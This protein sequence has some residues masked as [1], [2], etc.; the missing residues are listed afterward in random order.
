MTWR[1]PVPPRFLALG[2]FVFAG[3]LKAGPL[4]SRLPVDLTLLTGAIL[5][6]TVLLRWLRGARV[7]SAAGLGLVLGWF[8]TFLPGAA[9]TA[10]T[11]YGTRKLATLA[12]FS[13]LAA[14]APFF[15]VRDRA[16]QAHALEGLACLC[17]VITLDALSGMGQGGLQRLAASGGGTIALGRAAGFLALA[18]AARFAAG[19]R[20]APL[21]LAL[22]AAGTVAALFSG[23]RGPMGGLA[24][25]LVLLLAAAGRG[26]LR[27]LAA[28]GASA[29]AL[30]LSLAL[31]PAGSLRRV[32]D[33]LRGEFGASEAY[34]AL[35]AS[36]AW[37]RIPGAPL[38]LGLGGFATQVDL[39]AGVARQYPHNLLLET[40]LEAGWACGLATVALLG[41][42]LGR[43]WRSGEALLFAGVG[44]WTL[45]ALVSGD[46]NDNRP[47]FALL[48]T[49]L[50]RPGKDLP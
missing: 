31:G 12:T 49:A 5:A 43:A 40:T 8:L 9:A 48:A 4:L 21:H 26:R 35:A 44:F 37:A 2:G 17:G 22:A 38:G 28:A 14:T 45:N 11:P 42:A 29:A 39:D 16:D 47:L 1:W 15:L 25:G 41:A 3:D 23:S 24:L 33:F 32:A 13:L 46:V 20:T 10:A 18:G 36:S 6:G 27:L 7:A 50:A 34:R 19:G 30:H